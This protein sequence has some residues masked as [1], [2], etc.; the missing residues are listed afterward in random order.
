MSSRIGGLLAPLVMGGLFTI[1]G[2]WR[3]PLVLVAALGLV[4]CAGFWRW[5]RNS[6]DDMPKVNREERKLIET[7]RSSAR[8]VSHGAIPWG[9][10][11]RMPTVWAL[12]LMYGFLGFSGNFYLTMLPTYLEHHRHFSP[13]VTWSLSALP[14]G[15]GA[16]ACLVGGSISDAIIR[17]WGTRWGRRLVGAAGLLTAGLA[18]LAVPWVDHVWAV[19]FL[20]ILAFFGNDFRPA[21]A[22][23]ADIRTRY[24]GTLAG[25]MN[26][27]ASFFG[28][29]EVITI[30]RLFDQQNL[31][32]PFVLLA[33]GY[34]LGTLSWLGVDVEQTLAER[35]YGLVIPRS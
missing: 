12:W 5:F 25:G 14:F 15:F 24:T 8:P 34:A 21:W 33:L 23:A 29:I 7:G 1:M 10:M 32:L 28:A 19:G 31:V 18:I 3:M 26:M 22:A 17:R 30:G 2:G 35:D 20:L 27:M 4:W 11:V 13:T 6:P 16:I 9:R